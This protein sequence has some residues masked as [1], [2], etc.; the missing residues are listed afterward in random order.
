DNGVLLPETIDDSDT[1]LSPPRAFA[2]RDATSILAV[3]DFSTGASAFRVTLDPAS[4]LSLDQ[5]F[6]G[7]SGRLEGKLKLGN[8]DAFATGRVFDDAIGSVEGLLEPAFDIVTFYEDVQVDRSARRVLTIG[9]DIDIYDEATFA[10]VGRYDIP[11]SSSTT[12]LAGDFLFIAQSGSVDRYAL[13]DLQPNLPAEP[14]V[15]TDVSGLWI[16]GTYVQLDC[17]FTEA[18]FDPGRD[19]LYAGLPNFSERGNSIAVIDP[20]T[21]EITTWVPVNGTPKSLNLSSDGATLYAILDET[22][23]VIEVDLDTLVPTDVTV[24]GFRLMQPVIGDGNLIGSRSPFSGATS[25]QIFTTTDGGTAIQRDSSNVDIFAIDA[26]GVTPVSSLPGAAFPRRAEQRGNFF[27]ESSGTRFDFASQSFESVCALPPIAPELDTRVGPDPGSDLVYYGAI[28]DPNSLR[29]TIDL[30][31]C[32]PVGRAVGAEVSV[33]A[34][35]VLQG[36][37]TQLVSVSGNRVVVLTDT[38]MAL[39]DRPPLSP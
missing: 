20:A 23:K 24:L 17:G 34:F 33:F 5:E 9:G 14:C 29:E 13:G 8:D 6:P 7:L 26:S 37:M 16:D 19:R 12:L 22:S 4:G 39:L 15:R 31:A 11:G 38:H 28:G 21:L 10:Q 30:V 18:V 1:T 32:D 27:Y 36:R 3:D 35:K 2:F 25:D